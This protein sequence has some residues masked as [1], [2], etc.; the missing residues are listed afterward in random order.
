MQLRRYKI[1]V[2]PA[3]GRGK[4]RRQLPWLQELLHRYSCEYDLQMTSEPMEAAEIANRAA[5]Q[6][7]DAVVAFGGDGTINEVVNGL[8][9]TDGVLGVLPCGTGNDFARCLGLSK[10]LA[11]ALSVLIEG[12][13]CTVDLGYTSTR[14][15]INGIGIGFD[16]LVNYESR[17]LRGLRGTA[18]Y[19]ASILRTLSKY[20]ALD[21]DIRFN[22]T[23]KSGKT[24]LIAAGNGFSV[25][26]GIML[27][28]EARLDDALLDICHVDD[29]G[30]GTI[31]RHFT[32]LF[33]GGIDRVKQVTT[34]RSPQLEVQCAAGM[35]VHMD[36]EV[37]A[38][39]AK[40]LS[41]KIAPGALKVIGYTDCST[42]RTKNAACTV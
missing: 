2:N 37:I 19:L 40:N 30:L 8:V 1:I 18:L 36:G 17:Q 41:V 38:T 42:E 7:W 20:K 28:P 22:G 5:T 16:A 33:N 13:Q 10:D 9:G 14:Y 24:Y 3:A 31:M 11:Q 39:Q 25:G 23:S 29:V 6:E 27:T 12:R 26:G 15:F 32:K 21:M 4:A 34:A 35:P